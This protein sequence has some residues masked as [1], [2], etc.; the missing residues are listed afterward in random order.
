MTQKERYLYKAKRTD[1][2][3]WVQGALL[4]HDDG[5]ATILNQNPVDGSLQGFEVDPSTICQ[6]TT[7]TDRNGNLV[8]EN[9][10]LKEFTGEG[11][12]WEIAKVILGEYCLSLGWCQAGVKSLN[13]YNTNL[14]KCALN[15]YDASKCE[16][17][18]NVFD[19][20]ELLE[21]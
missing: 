16:I 9:D 4:W 12:D 15:R 21:K 2:R 10:Y 6:C 5:A 8:W 20:P 13:Q 14:F 18:G 7:F 3:E 1:N 19:N 17:V 11:N